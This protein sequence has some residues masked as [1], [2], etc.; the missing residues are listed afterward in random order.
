M[1]YAVRLRLGS[2]VVTKPAARALAH[3]PLRRAPPPPQTHG[4]F[5][6][7]LQVPEPNRQYALSALLPAPLPPAGGLVVQYEA[8]TPEAHACGGAYLKLL[9]PPADWAPARLRKKT[10]YSIMFGPDRCGG[11]A[12]VRAARG[13]ARRA[14]RGPCTPGGGEAEERRG[15]VCVCLSC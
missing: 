5:D 15:P 13:A 3:Q 9:S 2:R 7:S 4:S 10:P 14:G 1:V 11:A 12:R 8:Q 6:P